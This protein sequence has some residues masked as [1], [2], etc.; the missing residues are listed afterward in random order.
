MGKHR[1]AGWDVLSP[2]GAVAEHIASLDQFITFARRHHVLTNEETIV[3]PRLKQ[4]A[5]APINTEQART[6]FAQTL[7]NLIDGLDHKSQDEI[8]DLAITVAPVL[9]TSIQKARAANAKANQ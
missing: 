7:L 1:S 2:D 3:L 9:K 8:L 5:V 4:S 6:Q